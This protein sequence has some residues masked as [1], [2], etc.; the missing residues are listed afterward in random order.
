MV[1]TAY[2]GQTVTLTGEFFSGGQLV[3]PA[4]VTVGITDPSGT[5]EQIPTSAVTHVA[6]GI[7]QFTWLV[8]T[9]APLGNHTVTWTGTSPSLTVQ[10]A[11]AVTASSSATWCTLPDV[12]LI[13]G[14]Q[15][16]QDQLLQAGFNIDVAAARAFAV[17]GTR[18]GSRDLYW[19][20]MATAY[21]AAWLAT[22]VDAFNRIDALDIS[23]G[24][25]RTQLRDTAM[26]LAPHARRALKRVSWLKARSVHIRAPFTDNLGAIG[27]DPLSSAADWLGP[28]NPL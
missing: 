18:V 27:L 2:Q 19:L 25:S 20:R 8:P 12:P 28:W 14:V 17:D 4:T 1:T 10:E 3:D 13:T 7:V 21:Q 6:V 11:L 9:A 16:T 22:Q 5:V 26:F 24:R 15:V 23:Q